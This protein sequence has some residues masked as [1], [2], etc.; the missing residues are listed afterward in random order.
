MRRFDHHSSLQH[1][2]HSWNSMLKINMMKRKKKLHLHG[3]ESTDLFAVWLWSFFITLFSPQ[4]L[5]NSK[6]LSLQ[7][8]MSVASLNLREQIHVEPTET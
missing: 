2:T 5:L 8:R 3:M 7:L 6:E 4:N 1:W